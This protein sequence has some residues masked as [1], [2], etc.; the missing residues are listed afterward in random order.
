MKWELI[1][2]VSVIFHLKRQ[3]GEEGRGQEKKEE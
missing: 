1:F 2:I 3:I